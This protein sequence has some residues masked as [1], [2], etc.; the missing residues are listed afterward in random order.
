MSNLHLKKQIYN[1]C[2][3]YAYWLISLVLLFITCTQKIN[4][5]KEGYKLSGHIEGFKDS[6]TIYLSNGKNLDSSFIINNLFHFS[7]KI[8]HH[9]EQ[10]LLRIKGKQYFKY[11]WLENSIINLQSNHDFSTIKIEGSKTQEEDDKV[12]LAIAPLRTEINK[13][14]SVLKVRYREDNINAK[15]PDYKRIFSLESTIDSI[16][17]EYAF[18]KPNSKISI[19]LLVTYYSTWGKNKTVKIYNK[20]NGENK[21]SATVEEVRN[22]IKYNKNLNVNDKYVDFKLNDLNGKTVRLSDFEGKIILLEFW[23]SWCVPCREHNPALLKIY[24]KYKRKGFEVVAVSIDDDKENWKRAVIQDKLTWINISNSKNDIN[25]ATLIYGVS[26]IPSNF[27]INQKGIII[28]RDLRGDN[29]EMVL[30]NLM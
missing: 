20:L 27:L 1:H 4:N 25:E 7:G 5:K 14:S 9:A 24:T 15:D 18:A 3:N 8:Q 17:Y 26:E 13:L 10:A 21:N 12:N 29:L 30:S 22:F 16:Y 11:I 28:G 23:A 6:T 19:D 2:K